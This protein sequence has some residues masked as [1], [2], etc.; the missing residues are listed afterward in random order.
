MIPAFA[1][2]AGFASVASFLT[3]VWAIQLRSR[4]AGMVDPV[5]SWSLGFLGVLYALLGT[6]PVSTRL[7]L[8]VLAG[9]WG[10][11]LGTHL[12]FRNAGKPEDARYAKFRAEWGAQADR[13]M[14]WFFQFQAVM[15]LLLSVGFLVVAYSPAAPSPALVVLAVAIWLLSVVGE[16]LADRQMERFRGDPANRGK[17]CNRGLWRYSRHPNYFFE[18]L[19]WL[20]Y[21]PLALGS[22]WWPVAL[23]PAAIMAWLLLKM[24][25]VPILEAHLMKSRPGYAEYVRS[26]SVFVPWPP[27]GSG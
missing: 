9:V 24:S 27:K 5:W 4:N 15:A 3:I 2:A 25:G 11:R 1:I 13:N 21:L 22:P 16:G 26:T 10:L 6:A 12:Y 19:H 14:F 17:V 8:A 23:L 20:A 7:V 18:S